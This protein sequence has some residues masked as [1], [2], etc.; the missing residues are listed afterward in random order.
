MF[1]DPIA[2]RHIAI[3]MR[4]SKFGK[5]YAILDMRDSKTRIEDPIPHLYD[6]TEFCI[7]IDTI[8]AF[9]N[10]LAIFTDPE[11][12]RFVATAIL[13]GQI[14]F[15]ARVTYGG[16]SRRQ[17]MTPLPLAQNITAFKD[18]QAQ[19]II[20]EA[21]LG[22]SFGRM[23]PETLRELAKNITMFTDAQ[24]QKVIARAIRYQH[25]DV[26][27][28]RHDDSD[29]HRE[30][31][32]NLAVFTD[33]DA[34]RTILEA[35][36]EGIFCVKTPWVPGKFKTDEPFCKPE[37]DVVSAIREHATRNRI[38][39][40]VFYELDRH[41]TWLTTVQ[42]AVKIQEAKESDEQ[43]REELEQAHYS[44][45]IVRTK[46]NLREIESIPDNWKQRLVDIEAKEAKK[47]ELN[48]RRYNTSNS[49]S[50]QSASSNEPS[51]EE[52]RSRKED[53][54]R[55]YAA[56]LRYLEGLEKIERA[57][58]YTSR[59]IMESQ[60]REQAERDRQAMLYF[61]NPCAYQGHSGI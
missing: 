2:Q 54:D 26:C 50:Y 9:A 40:N 11:A 13:N 28:N 46:L 41:S 38:D 43:L 30:L 19:R 56:H 31:A 61:N 53:M 47:R 25:L 12:Q 59:I 15:E 21:I 14:M 58:E 7:D 35:I 36:R 48:S 20:A 51:Y 52:V 18:G 24:A 29:T 39:R 42:H 4:D 17:M 22:S 5:E 6:K 27:G 32:K 57:R 16:S 10:N 37:G 23:R 55:G 49:T 60:Q 34:Q 8:T 33:A 1:T 44:V 3:A 45:P